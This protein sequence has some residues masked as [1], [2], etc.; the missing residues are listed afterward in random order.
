M[1]FSHLP[2]PYLQPASNIWMLLL[3]GNLVPASDHKM[4]KVVLFIFD[5][6]ESQGRAG[7]PRTS[8]L[9]P[10]CLTSC[11]QLSAAAQMALP[12]EG[13]HRVLSAKGTLT[14]FCTE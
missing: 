10:H 2:R 4:P 11:G 13:R 12:I 1:V 9:S 6:R 5:I 7:V 3:R 8:V 14:R